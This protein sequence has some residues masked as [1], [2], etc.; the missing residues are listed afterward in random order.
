[1]YHA[2]GGFRAMKDL[3]NQTTLEGQAGNSL[4]CGMISKD[5]YFEP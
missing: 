3:P 1:M 4:A 2:K 5:R